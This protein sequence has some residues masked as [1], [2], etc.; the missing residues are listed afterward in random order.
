MIE[1]YSIDL[2]SERVDLVLDK[3]LEL[4]YNFQTLKSLPESLNEGMNH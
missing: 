4:S 1:Y 2:I 3:G